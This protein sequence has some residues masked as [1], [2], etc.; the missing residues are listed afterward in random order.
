MRRTVI[1]SMTEPNRNRRLPRLLVWIVLVPILAMGLIYAKWEFVDHRLVTIRDGKLWQSAAMPP[2]TL[3]DV[4]N[5]RGIQTVFDLRDSEPE[6]VAAE[7]AAV[8][9]AGLA[10]VHVPMS[11]TEPTQADM[12]RFLAAMKSAK[13]PSLVHC[14]HGQGR[15]VLAVSV[16]RIEEEGWSNED[17]FLATSRLPEELRFLDGVLGWIR[18]FDRDTPKGKVLLEWRRK[19]TTPPVGGSK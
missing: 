11:A 3:V 5:A 14:Q 7:K 9:K 6:L 19:S 2:D 1:D 10:F 13:Q 8:E 16:W 17:A 15:S 18:R 12:E 4:M